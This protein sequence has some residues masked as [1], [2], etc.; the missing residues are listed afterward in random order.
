MAGMQ[1]KT[2]RRPIARI[3]VTAENVDRVAAEALA[4]LNSAAGKLGQ[5]RA[6]KVL[7]E[8][9]KFRAASGTLPEPTF[10]R[11]A[12]DLEGETPTKERITKPSRR[13][14]GRAGLSVTQTLYQEGKRVQTRI[15]RSLKAANPD[16]SRLPIAERVRLNL[17]AIRGINPDLIPGIVSQ[18]GVHYFTN[19]KVASTEGG[20]TAIAA[21]EARFGDDLGKNGVRSIISGGVGERAEMG[22]GNYYT[23]DGQV[24]ER[25]GS[26]RKETITKK[27]NVPAPKGGYK[28]KRTRKAMEAGRDEVNY[29]EL[30]AKSKPISPSDISVREIQ[31]ML[32]RETDP[33]K[34]MVL[35]QAMIARQTD[36]AGAEAE[37]TV[38]IEG[39]TDPK[40]GKTETARARV[41]G[42][43]ETSAGLARL[44]R[45]GGAQNRQ[46]LVDLA[47]R[48]IQ[49]YRSKFGMPP[50]GWAPVLAA[51]DP[52]FEGMTQ[53]ELRSIA[54][55]ARNAIKEDAKAGR[56]SKPAAPSRGR[57]ELSP[58]GADVTGK[59]P[60]RRVKKKKVVSTRSGLAEQV[61]V[62]PA[63][64]RQA[65]VAR[66]EAEVARDTAKA[67]ERRKTERRTAAIKGELGP[68]RKPAGGRRGTAAV[69]ADLR[70]VVKSE[71]GTVPARPRSVG[72]RVRV[73]KRAMA[74]GDKKMRDATV[75]AAL[76]AA[77]KL[78][79]K[80]EAR[81]MADSLKATKSIRRRAAKA[82][83]LGI[84]S[85][86]GTNYILS[87]LE[88]DKKG[89][90]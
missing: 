73:T 78:G 21:I 37:K 61:T 41:G 83:L 35:Q 51:A 3:V 85:T 68:E 65:E 67:S 66:A 88:E 55:Q 86:F 39:E 16:F 38:M 36:I 5:D 19:E 79:G 90:R 22:R 26:T 75:Y 46:V 28:S 13:V 82:G 34:R 48:Q 32:A 25:T 6:L 57:V 53:S 44:S 60:K 62:E 7:R 69:S 80:P 56:P 24:R 71:P 87:L 47:V 33:R 43:R 59:G 77:S 9:A 64:K 30:V 12:A 40:T 76:E 17:A 74:P 23:E 14:G 1:G 10:G 58:S 8:V 81:R 45:T 2:K 49:E 11:A 15:F 52:L 72:S 31:E 42:Q 84:A 4:N 50:S 29:D 27:R 54:R 20:R 18:M 70:E 63:G 89:R